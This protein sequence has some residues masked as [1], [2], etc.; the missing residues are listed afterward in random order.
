ME[1][2]QVMLLPQLPVVS[3]GSFFLELLPLLELFG[4][5]EGD[6]IYTL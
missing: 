6:A 2:V 3:L 4:V 5:R 1:E